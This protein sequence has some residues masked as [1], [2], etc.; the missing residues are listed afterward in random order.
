LAAAAAV[1]AGAATRAPRAKRPPNFLYIM[2]DDMG[3]A[4][5]SC[6]GRTDYRTPAIDALAAQGVRFTSAYANSAVCTATRVALITGR[7]QYRLPI[8]LE[9]PLGTRH[10]GVPASAPTIASVLKAQGYVSSLIGK[11]HLGSL[12]DY[13]PLQ[14]G[15][16]EFWGFRGGG[17]DYFTHAFDGK[18]L[19]DGDQ[20]IERTG[21]LTDL[22]GDRAIDTIG[23]FQRTGRPWLVS[24][25]FNAP[26]W[27]WEGPGDGAESR[28][29]AAM[30]NPRSALGD[31]D[32]GTMA[33]YAAMVTRMDFQVG[34]IL[35]F[36][37]ARGLEQDTVVVF[38]SD[39]GGERFSTTWPFNGRK[40]ELL[41]GGLRIPAIVRWP[42][43]S[44]PGTTSDAQIMSMDWAPTFLAAT[45][46]TAPGFAPDGIDIRGAVGGGSLAERT[47]YW[48]YKHL[49]QQ[50]VRRG[51]L[52][53]LQIA[54]NSFLFD[55]VADPMERANLKTRQPDRY[56]ELKA[57]WEAWNAT[58]L[59]FDP[60]SQSA[61]F[62]AATM[63]D[64]FNPTG[65][66]AGP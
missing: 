3:Y 58:M 23:R 42:G 44:K 61:G 41:E 22:L 43:L 4:D 25:H 65:A 33:T 8:G 66:V 64:H 62:T 47:L 28:R 14:S 32:G 56:A 57:A 55:V 37:K 9:E 15:Y 31:Y 53:Y 34:R 10:V 38:T 48:R 17:V 21:Y 51:R 35:R 29:L 7:Y 5:L 2:A 26:H 19:W 6:Y 50:A 40:T 11:W 16:D 63:A 46:G 60:Q 18:D 20:P 27:P 52:K 39:N 30:P 24:L 12:P 45:G 13:G 59:P 1:P 54:G 49:G 36:L